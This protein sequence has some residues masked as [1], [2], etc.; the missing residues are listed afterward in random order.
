[1]PGL[2]WQLCVCQLFSQVTDDLGTQREPH[3]TRRSLSPP[4]R[5]N[6]AAR[7][8]E[9]NPSLALEPDPGQHRSQVLAAHRPTVDSA[10]LERG[11]RTWRVNGRRE[12]SVVRVVEGNFLG[13]D[14]TGTNAIDGKVL[15]VFT[16]NNRIGGTTPAARNII[17]GH[18]GMNVGIEMAGSSA[19][20][21]VVQ[22][23]F[24]GTDAS[25]TTMGPEGTTTDYDYYLL[26]T[27]SAGNTVELERRLPST[28]S[29]NGAVR[30]LN[31]SG[32][33]V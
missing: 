26:G 22:G 20:G 17:S 31:A 18:P 3:L 1:M 33:A 15:D 21:N 2:N 16:P 14:T 10:G 13:L 23:N 19:T 29:W 5:A 27:L 11:Q 9:F 8:T 7:T 28:S 24:I 32:V 4:S 30:V 12:H 6:V 25:G